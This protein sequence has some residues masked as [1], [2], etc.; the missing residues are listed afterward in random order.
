MKRTFTLA[1]FG[2]NSLCLKHSCQL[3]KG[4]D[5]IHVTSYRFSGSLQFFRSTRANKHHMSLRITL[6]NG[7]CSCHHRRQLLRN[8]PN[9]IREEL[10]C[11]HAPGRTAGSEQE[12]QFPCA[13]FLCIVMCLSNCSNICS[14]S[15]FIDICKAQFLQSR[16]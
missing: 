14:Q 9:H 2:M 5:K 7:S 8:I 12:R 6:L 11:K 15:H 16:L 3:L 1:F 10:L 13:D 4:N